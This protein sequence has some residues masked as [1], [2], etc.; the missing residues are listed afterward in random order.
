[1]PLNKQWTRLL[2]CVNPDNF[3]VQYICW[4]KQNYQSVL[5]ASVNFWRPLVEVCCQLSLR[6]VR[7]QNLISHKFE[8]RKPTSD[9]LIPI[10]LYI[11][12]ELQILLTVRL[13]VTVCCFRNLSLSC[14]WLQDLL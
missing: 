6:Q 2:V 1:M 9:C 14:N 11:N 13:K 12:K 4:Q 3:E 5:T 8:G 10:Q 7:S